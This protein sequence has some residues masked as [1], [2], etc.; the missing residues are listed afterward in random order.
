MQS[1]AIK[2]ADGREAN[3]RILL[4]ADQ[5]KRRSYRNNGQSAESVGEDKL[6]TVGSNDSPALALKTDRKPLDISLNL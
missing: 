6:A 3:H 2:V 5:A 1:P 4:S